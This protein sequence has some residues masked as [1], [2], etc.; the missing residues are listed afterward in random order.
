MALSQLHFQPKG[1]ILSGS[2]KSV[3]EEDAPHV[4]WSQL[5][6]LAV[7]ILGVCYGLHEIA[8][9]AG[10]EVLA[11][12]K[13]EYGPAEVEIQR[14]SSVADHVNKLFDGLGSQLEVYMSH[15]DKL[16]HAP[17]KWSV[18]ARTANA[19][20]AAV[21]HKSKPYYG[22]QSVHGITYALI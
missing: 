22:I 19:P 9:H 12:D 17:D 5:V 1:V 4:E 16:S 21:A 11:G 6:A 10:T 2:P 3:Y 8:H 20:F 14:L 18:I 7:P 15:G 13:K